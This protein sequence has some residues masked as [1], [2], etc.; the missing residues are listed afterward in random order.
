[1]IS[2]INLIPCFLALLVLINLMSAAEAQVGSTD[3]WIRVQSDNGEF[4]I[5]VPDNYSFVF[6][7][8][9][10]FESEWPID[11][12]LQDVSILNA[13]RDEILVSF[14]VYRGDPD[15]MGPMTKAATRHNEKRRSTKFDG[16]PVREVIRSDDKQ[17]F[18]ARYF[19]SKG[20]VYVVSVASRTG[21][22]TTAQ[23]FLQSLRFV[24][25]SK[26]PAADAVSLSKLRVTPIDFKTQN[27]EPYD[28]PKQAPARPPAGLNDKPMVI[29]SRVRASYI[30]SARN[31][32][33]TGAVRFRIRFSKDG[34]ISTIE[35][36]KTLPQGLLRQALFAA[37][38]LKVLPP[39]KDGEAIGAIRIIEYTFDIR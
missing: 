17:Y 35:V 28:P 5:E 22:T 14:E 13:Y 27:V 38:R 26:S 16:I 9:G 4:S 10:Y 30:A 33:V 6:D 32:N 37:L 19:K 7:R 3:K 24:P 29:V 1:M 2:R 12:L 31:H 36:L 34:Y 23:R 15:A 20:F 25:E 21:V 39:I 11:Y 18:A 8:T